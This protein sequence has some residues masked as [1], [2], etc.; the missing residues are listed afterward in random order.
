MISSSLSLCVSNR[1]KEGGGR[2]GGRACVK[3]W[4][5][6]FVEMQMHGENERKRRIACLP[7]CI[8]CRCSCLCA[9]DCARREAGNRSRVLLIGSGKEN[10]C[11][12]LAQSSSISSCE[13]DAH[14]KAHMNGRHERATWDFWWIWRRVFACRRWQQAVCLPFWQ[15]LSGHEK[16]QSERKK[17][18]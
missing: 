17:G 7:A 10:V 5:I 9:G 18:D 2:E 11:E 16:V 12:C 14:E 4:G 3:R 13:W 8:E 6:H 1:S 15:T